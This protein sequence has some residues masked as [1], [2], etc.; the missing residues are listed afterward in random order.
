MSNTLHLSGDKW[1][2]SGWSLSSMQTIVFIDVIT[3]KLAPVETGNRVKTNRR[4]AL[5]LA[6]SHR[7][8]D[9]TAAW[10]P[11]TRFEALRD[12]ARHVRRLSRINCVRGIG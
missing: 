3:P 6:R 1:E 2:L 10:I 4:S 7:S 5:R 8:G 9:L 11:G 12:M